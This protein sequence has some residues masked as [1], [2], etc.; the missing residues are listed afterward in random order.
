[1]TIL[2]IEDDYSIQQAMS[3]LLKKEYSLI[4]V[5]SLEKARQKLDSAISLILLDIGLPDGSG[6]DFIKEIRQTTNIPVIFL[7]VHDSEEMISQGLDLGADDYITKPFSVKVLLSR[8]QSV[9]R[10]YYGQNQHIIQLDHLYIDTL[11]ETV[12]ANGQI[13]ELTPIETKLLF[14][15]IHANGKVLTRR[16]LLEQIWDQNEKYIEDN[17]L[18]VH[19]KR[20]KDKVGAKYFKTIRSVGYAFNRDY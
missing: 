9:L 8:I 6:L 13:I 4:C 7:T 15:L 14:S 16:F 1:M 3:Q 11:K 12:K 10:R 17:T 2:L 18:S 20:L 19:M 5:D